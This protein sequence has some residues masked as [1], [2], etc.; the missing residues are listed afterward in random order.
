MDTGEAARPGRD[1]ERGEE[2][3]GEREGDERQK[4]E[5]LRPSADRASTRRGNVVATVAPPDSSCGHGT[6]P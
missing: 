3:G 4:T 6:A 5:A 1:A 2:P